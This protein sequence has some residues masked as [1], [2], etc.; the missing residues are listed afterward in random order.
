MKLEE[1]R[2][3]LAETISG[4][5]FEGKTYFTG[6][7][8]RDYLLSLSDAVSKERQYVEQSTQD[9]DIAVEFP[10]GG[11]LLSHFLHQRL[12]TSH[13]TVYN[14]FGTASTILR[15]LRLELV[16][17]RK[18]S[19]RARNRKPSVLAG[20]LLDD[21]KRR[22]FTVNAIYINISDGA[23]FDP[24][25]RG[26]ED[27]K[28]GVIRSVRDP[29]GVFEE[30]P[31]RL[32]RAI[33]FA[34]QL[35]FS[36]DEETLAAI[37]ASHAS[38][39]DISEER[40]AEEFCKIISLPD[41][42]AAISGIELMRETGILTQ[43]LPELQALV[44]LAQNHFH[45]L[46]AYYHTLEVL[47][48][49]GNIPNLRLAALLHDVGKAQTLTLSDKGNIH[50]YYHHSVGAHLAREILKRFHIRKAD[51]VNIAFAIEKHMV[52]KQGGEKGEKL[53]D[54]TLRRYMEHG[55]D[56]LELL[57]GLIHADNLS[58]HPDHCLPDQIPALRRRIGLLKEVMQRFIL[59]GR[60]LME[61]FAISEGSII[62]EMLKIAKERWFENP[63]W[64]KQELLDMLRREFFPGVEG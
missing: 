14:T 36:I 42:E 18:E 49:T 64:G 16:M 53:K 10:D 27:L 46:D 39:K 24:T 47:R 28:N 45:H 61:E 58:H 1:L 52:F 29:G 6:G 25:Q 32:L 20:D 7:C 5:P 22:D 54:S 48:K 34:V 35:D 4:T 21:A 30:D 8:V 26:F 57:L 62:G 40:I 44:G 15:G 19:Y 12:G 33:R 60:D 31:L 9:V 13:P 55:D 43:I 37:C 11:V 23:L 3:Q 17:T 51:A 56:K 63:E 41:I 2:L 50:F 38:I 59:T